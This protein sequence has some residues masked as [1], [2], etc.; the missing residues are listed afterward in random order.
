MLCVPGT[1]FSCFPAV[2]QLAS[3]TKHTLGNNI[4]CIIS[5]LNIAGLMP[6]QLQSLHIGFYNV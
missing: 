3:V 5:W 4:M 2:T 1:R 6:M